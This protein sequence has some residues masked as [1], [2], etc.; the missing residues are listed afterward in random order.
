MSCSPIPVDGRSHA[1]TQT[2][3]EWTEPVTVKDKRFEKDIKEIEYNDSLEPGKKTS[4][5]R[6]HDE[7]NY[8]RIDDE[9]YETHFKGKKETQ[10]VNVNV[11]KLDIL[12]SQLGT[13][14]GVSKESF[15]SL[16]EVDE[17]KK[18]LDNHRTR[19]AKII[20]DEAKNK[21]IDEFKDKSGYLSDPGC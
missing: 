9:K 12:Q 1:Q 20:L 6:M 2:E 4:Y 15:G 13:Q 16:F 3:L 10:N 17:H 18:N 5:Q 7:T 11:P 21:V 8:L 19:I 14:F